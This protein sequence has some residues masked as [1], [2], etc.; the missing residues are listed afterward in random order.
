MY[1]IYRIYIYKLLKNLNVYKHYSLYIY[2]HCQRLTPCLNHVALY[3]E[4][5]WK[6]ENAA[7]IKFWY[8]I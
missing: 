8:F 2:E 6:Q 7:N 3:S 4:P 5:Y 1:R